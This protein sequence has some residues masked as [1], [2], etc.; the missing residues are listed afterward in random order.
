MELTAYLQTLARFNGHPPLGVNATTFTAPD[1]TN[2]VAAFQWA[3]TLGGEC[4]LTQAETVLYTVLRWFQWAP[5]LGGECYQSARSSRA[6]V[7][8]RGFNGHPP[9]GVNATR[10][11][12]ATVRALPKS[13]VER[14][15]GHPPLGVNA[16]RLVQNALA[17]RFRK[18]VSMGTHP[19]G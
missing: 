15:N 19:W 5:T 6:F 13:M 7:R 12:A 10:A 14:F 11:E 16:T 8:N 9:L 18:S 2:S 4:Y 17:A 1:R 3:P